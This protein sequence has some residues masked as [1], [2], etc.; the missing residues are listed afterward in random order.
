MYKEEQKIMLGA[1][2]TEFRKRQTFEAD[3]AYGRSLEV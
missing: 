3:N 2:R 1:G